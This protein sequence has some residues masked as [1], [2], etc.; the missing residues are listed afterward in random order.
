MPLRSFSQAEIVLKARRRLEAPLLVMVWLS[1]TM[2]AVAEGSY[3]YFLAGTLTVGVNLAATLRGKEFYLDRFFVYAVAL[4][5]T[6]LV[7]VEW[8]TARGGAE[9]SEPRLLTAITHFI[10]VIQLCKLLERKRNRDYVQMLTLSA[11]VVLSASLVSDL[12]WYAALCVVYVILAGHVGIALTLKRGLD[13]TAQARLQNEA[14]PPPPAQVAWNAIR[15]WPTGAIRRHLMSALL[16]MGICGIML[17]AAAPRLSDAMDTVPRGLGALA[18]LVDSVHLGETSEV[19]LSDRIVMRIRLRN[20]AGRPVTQSS[21]QYFCAST[22]SRYENSAWQRSNL[23]SKTP[24]PLLGSLRQTAVAQEISMLATGTPSLPAGFPVIDVETDVGNW[25]LKATGVAELSTRRSDAY[26]IRYTAWS[27][28]QPLTPRQR[29]YLDQRREAMGVRL[30]GPVEPPNVPARV[31]DLAR[32]WCG[33]LLAERSA[34]PDRRDA[35]DLQIAERLSQRLSADYLYTLD[36]SDADPSRDGVEDFLFYMKQ[37]HCEYFASALTVMCQS[38]GVRARLAT[39]YRTDEVDL[40]TGELLVRDRDAHAWCLVYTPSTDFVIVDPSP[41]RASSD[42]TTGVWADLQDWWR[43]VQFLWYE[44]VIGYDAGSRER[45]TD[46]L[47]QKVQ[48]TVNWVRDQARQMGAGLWGLLV[49]GEV[50]NALIHLTYVVVSA[51]GFVALLVAGR[52]AWRRWRLWLAC[53][54]G[55]AVPPA[56]MAFMRQL[57]KRFRRHGLPARPDQ[58]PREVLLEASRRFDL[59]TPVIDQLGEFYYSLRWGKKAA[60]AAELAGAQRQAEQIIEQ[61]R[62]A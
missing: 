31:V 2:V 62:G 10:I 49:R 13:A 44:K 20:G 34:N 18:G 32:E 21:I 17:F 19:Y 51:T 12:L 15:D 9:I 57:L 16:F 28:V 40:T 50:N 47:R 8:F 39:G 43:R 42:K 37:G 5:G 7:V 54:A 1:I 30:D 46:Y 52:S 56:Q 36:L 29:R 60:T 27:W 24:L 22:A 35:L 45:L 59:P 4:L 6:G 14:A 38:L 33:D 26:H 53:R 25:R 58:T 23:P 3:H 55:Q 11:L 41:A 61:L 48:L